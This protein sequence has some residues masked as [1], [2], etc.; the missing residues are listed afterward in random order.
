MTS[1]HHLLRAGVVAAT[2]AFVAALLMGLLMTLP[3]AAL[4][5]QPSYPPARPADFLAVVNNYPQQLLRFYAADSL[6][7]LSYLLVFAVLYGITAGRVPALPAVGL[8]AGVV[9]GICDALENGFFITFA[10]LA[11]Q[12]EVFTDGEIP[13]LVIYMF[14]NMK[15]MGAFLAMAAFGLA[16]PRETR[17]SWLVAGLALLFPLVGAAGIAL[18][19]LTD[20]RGLFL[21]VGMLLFALYFW[22]RL[23]QLSSKPGGMKK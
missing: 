20:I 11:Q 1:Q 8:G 6:F 9:T 15:W 17:L 13:F 10:L 14:A 16:L 5:I 12:G 23:R 3:D 7:V 4:S 2:T 19:A 22:Q 18:P 21:L